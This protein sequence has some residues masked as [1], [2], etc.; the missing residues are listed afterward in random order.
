M[1]QAEAEDGSQHPGF[2]TALR[3]PLKTPLFGE[4]VTEFLQLC[5]G[6]TAPSVH[7][8]IYRLVTRQRVGIQGFVPT[9]STGMERHAHTVRVAGLHVQEIAKPVLVR[10][11][12]FVAGLMAFL[13][14]LF[15]HPWAASSF[16]ELSG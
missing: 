6:I 3:G 15:D 5:S 1:H 2:G 14:R 13:C 11:R 9:P 4:T 12:F 8:C 16:K 7:L 10:V